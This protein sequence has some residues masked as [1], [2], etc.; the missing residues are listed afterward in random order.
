MIVANKFQTGFDQPKLCA[1][2][3]DKRVSGVEAVQTLSRLNRMAPGKTAE[4]VYVVDFANEPEEILAAFRTWY[5]SAE[6]SGPQDYDVVYDL[7]EQLDRSGLYT[8]AEVD[9]VAR[10][11]TGE[12]H[13]TKQSARLVNAVDAPVKRFNEQLLN[14]NDSIARWN[15]LIA[16]RDAAGDER[17]AAEAESQRAEQDAERDSLPKLRDGM[18][19]FVRLY[20]FVAQVVPLGDAELEKLARFVRLFRKRLASVPVERIDLA[21]LQMT[22]WTLKEGD[23]IGEG[24]G[25]GDADA[26]TLDPVKA[27]IAPGKDRA[28]ERLSEII[29]ALNDLFGEGVGEGDTLKR[30]T[31]MMAVSEMARRD[32]TVRKQLDAGNTDEQV[33]RGG[34]LTK[35][36]EGAVFDLMADGNDAADADRLLKDRDSMRHYAWAVLRLMRSGLST[37]ELRELT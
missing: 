19:K 14:L 24:L 36:V 25:E 17:G 13:A 33:M 35:A 6:V 32:D 9:E 20:E 18:S 10:I 34:D 8:Q 22:H 2:Y 23:R 29:R 5:D 4:S 30:V 15:R 28:R 12:L 21:G 3:L 31:N 27:A 11:L 1:M 37:D 16:D 26:P 7:K